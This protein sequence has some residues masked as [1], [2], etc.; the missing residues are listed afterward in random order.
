MTPVRTLFAIIFL[1]WAGVMV[2]GCVNSPMSNPQPPMMYE[3]TPI[4]SI[5][6]FPPLPPG[7]PENISSNWAGYVVETNFASPREGS[8]EA[9]EAVW[10]IP[11]VDCTGTQAADYSSSFWVGIDGYDSSSVE[12]IGTDSDCVQGS[13]T[14]YAWYEMYPKDSVTLDLALNPGDEVLAKVTYL[15]NQEFQLSLTDKTSNQTVSITETSTVAMRSSAEWI[16]EAPV[17]QHRILPLSDF[18][19]VDFLNISVTVNGKTGSI[20]SDQWEYRSIVMETPDRIIKATPS[21]LVNGDRFS[22]VWEHP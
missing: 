16:A 6:T 15:G 13:P 11:A 17:Y 20:L 5:T 14:Y 10:N 8:I 21:E 1:V 4:P 18:G 7:V 22:V 19:P 3:T 2:L 9:V 12:Q